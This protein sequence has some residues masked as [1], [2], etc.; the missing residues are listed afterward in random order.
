M[1]AKFANSSLIPSFARFLSNTSIY[2]MDTIKHLLFFY[3]LLFSGLLNAQIADDFSDGNFTQNPT[4]MGD[5]A[6]FIVNSAGMLQLLA[7]T[8]GSSQLVVQ[9]HIPDS[10]VWMLDLRLAFA[11]SASNFLRIYLLADQADLATAGDP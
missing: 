11:P 7:P 2:R 10:A 5:S 3:F 9:G 6:N 1:G 4:W 8:G